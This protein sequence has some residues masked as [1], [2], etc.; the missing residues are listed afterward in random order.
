MIFWALAVG[1]AGW[2]LRKEWI[3]EAA[4]IMATKMAEKMA[5]KM[6]KENKS[7]QLAQETKQVPPTICTQCGAEASTGA[8]FCI[9]CGS[10]ISSGLSG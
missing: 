2:H 9:H 1:H 3:E 8:K 4:E 7:S 5:E 6:V 10:P